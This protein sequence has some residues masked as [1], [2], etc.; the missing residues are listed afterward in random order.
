MK[1]FLMFLCFLF[2]NIIEAIN[3]GRIL[4]RRDKFCVVSVIGKSDFDSKNCKAALI[5]EVI[6]KNVFRGAFCQT[7]QTNKE[8]VWF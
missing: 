2:R 6:G 7:P 1:K 4:C 3:K 8:T 5:D